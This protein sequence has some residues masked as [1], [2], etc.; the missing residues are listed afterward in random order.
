MSPPAPLPGHQDVSVGIG[1]S[2][3]AAHGLHGDVGR[4]AGCSRAPEVGGQP[5]RRVFAV[6]Q[7][8]DGGAGVSRSRRRACAK[9]GEVD[10]AAADRVCA[11]RSARYR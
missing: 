4:P 8:V 3:E 11:Q 5:G 10:F 1:I 6:D 9:R 2:P 7:L